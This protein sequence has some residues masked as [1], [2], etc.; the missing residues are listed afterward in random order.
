MVASW[1]SYEL[2][3]SQYLSYQ[4]FIVINRYILPALFKR[5]WMGS[6]AHSWRNNMGCMSHTCATPVAYSFGRAYIPV[7]FKGLL[8]E[9]RWNKTSMWQSS[10]F[11]PFFIWHTVSSGNDWI[12]GWKN[13][14][15]TTRNSSVWHRISSLSEIHFKSQIKHSIRQLYNS[16]SIL[17]I[18]QLYTIE[19]VMYL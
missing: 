14:D 5:R 19:V 11:F 18:L 15:K 3:I 2:P 9:I 17:F 4:I 10:F 16:F 6:K 7:S 13:L 8:I 12:K 1:S